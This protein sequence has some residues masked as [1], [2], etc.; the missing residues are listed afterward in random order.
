MSVD[1]DIGFCQN[2]YH[3]YNLILFFW[4]V[5]MKITLDSRRYYNDIGEILRSELPKFHNRIHDHTNHGNVYVS[6]NDVK[7]EVDR[8][9]S[10]SVQSVY[11]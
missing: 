6:S 10:N 5:C 1:S 7:V 2:T 8:W 11:N 9:S 3:E 4:V